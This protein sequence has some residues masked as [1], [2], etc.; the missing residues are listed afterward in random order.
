MLARSRCGRVCVGLVGACILFVI[1]LTGCKRKA[2]PRSRGPE[3]TETQDAA[4]SS[5][6][7]RP[8]GR[9]HEVNA[10]WYDV[11]LVSLA[12]RRAGLSEMTAAHNKL[13]IGTLVRVTHLANG[14]SVTVRITDRGIHDRRV[15]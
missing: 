12:K 10:A 6:S 2:V 13:P 11:P 5:D 4:K 14:K 8:A 15:K 9:V 7:S 3:R 1:P